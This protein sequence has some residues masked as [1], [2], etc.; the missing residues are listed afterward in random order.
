V[1]TWPEVSCVLR[2]GCDLGTC[3]EGSAKKDA[4]TQVGTP[5][6]SP[7]ASRNADRHMDTL[8]E[9]NAE[10]CD[11]TFRDLRQAVSH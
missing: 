11:V 6:V 4:A 3:L 10:L 5:D 9:Q 1:V 2:A 8:C 7:V